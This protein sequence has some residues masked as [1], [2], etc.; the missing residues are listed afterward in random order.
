MVD[1]KILLTAPNVSA[2]EVSEVMTA[3]L[4]QTLNMELPTVEE[5]WTLLT[6]G[7]LLSDKLEKVPQPSILDKLPAIGTSMLQKERK[8]TLK[9]TTSVVLALLAASM[10][11]LKSSSETSHLPELDFAALLTSLAILIW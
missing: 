11:P 5:F 4:L 7:K 8:S 3:L 1:T 9:L 2:Q 6:P 10:D